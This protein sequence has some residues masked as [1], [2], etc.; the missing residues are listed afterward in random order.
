MMIKTHRPALFSILFL[1]VGGLL[2]GFVGGLLGAG[3]GIIFT[4]VLSRL[5]P[6]DTEGRR[7]V[8]ACSLSVTLPLSLITLVRYF[9]ANTPSLS[10]SADGSASSLPVMLLGSLI[11]GAVGGALLGR[12]RSRALSRIFAL[13]C[14]LSG[15][16]MLF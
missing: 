6:K 4:L 12:L 9:A 2:G 10:F 7:S 14:A 15:L 8:F 11:G 5:L 16:I 1:A 3:G 13:L